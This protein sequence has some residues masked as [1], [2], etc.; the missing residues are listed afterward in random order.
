VTE[1]IE[2]EFEVACSPEHA[3]DTWANRTSMWWPPSHSVSSVPGLVVTFEPRPG[4]RI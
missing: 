3:F 1:P 4:G 2:I